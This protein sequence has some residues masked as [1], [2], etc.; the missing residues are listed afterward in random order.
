MCIQKKRCNLADL[1]TLRF[2]NKINFTSCLELIKKGAKV[3]TLVLVKF[4]YLK[5]LYLRRLNVELYLIFLGIIIILYT[6]ERLYIKS[7]D[8]NI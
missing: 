7:H 5:V 1:F 2:K 4:E 6:L 3:T 8:T